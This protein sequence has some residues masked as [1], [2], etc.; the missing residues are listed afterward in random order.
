MEDERLRENERAVRE[1]EGLERSR[2]RW[3]RGIWEIDR[4]ESSKSRDTGE[5]EERFVFRKLGKFC[6]S[7]EN[8]FGLKFLEG[9]EFGF[10][11]LEG[12]NFGFRNLEGF[13]GNRRF[14]N[15]GVN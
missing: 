6:L 13:G 7:I 4:D 14:R 12:I 5:R 1:I 3:D 15:L 2:E 9:I 10:R 8:G 11:I